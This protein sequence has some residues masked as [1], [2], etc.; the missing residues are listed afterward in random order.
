MKLVPREVSEEESKQYGLTTMAVDQFGNL[1]YYPPFVM[2]LSDVTM[3]CAMA[4]EVLHVVLLHL[5]RIGTRDQKTWNVA[6]DAAVNDTLAKTFTV[7]DAWVKIPKM[8]GKASEEIYDWIIK[9][10]QTY[11]CPAG[12]GFDNHIFGKDHVC[13]F[14]VGLT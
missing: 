3:K 1:M 14:L 2:G 5:K 8:A 12:G 11:K 6:V 4:H 7:P 9:N 10:A 13:Y